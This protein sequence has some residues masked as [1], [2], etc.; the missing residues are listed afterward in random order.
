[1]SIV[2]LPLSALQ[3]SAHFPLISQGE[4]RAFLETGC[5]AWLTKAYGKVSEEVV[6]SDPRRYGM[7]QGYFKVEPTA[8]AELENLIV[9]LSHQHMLGMSAAHGFDVDLDNEE[10]EVWKTF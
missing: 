3:E 10:K 2:N 6:L 9:A 8:I 5:A 7:V 1:M 4:W